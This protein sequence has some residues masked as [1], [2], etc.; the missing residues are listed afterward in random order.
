MNMKERCK[1]CQKQCNSGIW[2]SPQFKDEKV[3]LFCSKDCRDEYISMKL[4]RIK[5]NYPKFYDKIM[6]SKNNRY[7]E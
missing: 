3:L 6:K 2:V 5:V 4:E 1:T 7:F